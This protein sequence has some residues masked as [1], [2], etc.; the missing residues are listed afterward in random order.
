MAKLKRVEIAAGRDPLR[1]QPGESRHRF[2]VFEQFL[3]MEKPRKLSV[4]AQQLGM[5]PDHVRQMAVQGQWDERI[6]L[7]REAARAAYRAEFEEQAR[8]AAR[9][10]RAVLQGML[11]RAGR[12]LMSL[13]GPLAPDQIF[14]LLDLA[15]KHRRS[16][17][18]DPLKAGVGEREEAPATQVNVEIKNFTDLPK[19]GQLQAIEDEVQKTWRWLAAA[20]NAEDE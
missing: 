15:L 20:K 5:N 6:R 18:G 16:L 14:R 10:D 7:D 2:E 17:F 9:Q 19:E 13:E 1:Q 8:E 4:L 12:E 3:Q 11:S